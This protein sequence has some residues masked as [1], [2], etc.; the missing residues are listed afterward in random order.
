[1]AAL[2]DVKADLRRLVDWFRSEASAALAGAG[3]P[4]EVGRLLERFHSDAHQILNKVEDQAEQDVVTVA[5][6][7]A[8]D[9]SAVEQDAAP[10][11]ADPQAEA[12]ASS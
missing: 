8:D 9:L 10:A 2:A 7:A 1:M 11:P 5:G 4:A 6:Q 12:P 3:L